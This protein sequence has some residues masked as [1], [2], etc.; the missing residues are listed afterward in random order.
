MISDPIAD[1]LTR[2]RN[3][4]L[5][6]KIIIDVSGSKLRERLADLLV[7]ESYIKK[8]TKDKSGKSIQLELLYKNGKPAITQVNKISK[9]G[10]RKY[11]G[12]KD[13]PRVLGGA[14]IVI[15]ST[16]KGLMNGKE[17]KKNRLGGEIICEIW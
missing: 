11:I 4:Y 12:V 16:S 8:V 10:L 2:I 9:P 3:G 5:A 17:A 1:M 15:L 7:K 6:R 14:G 13:I